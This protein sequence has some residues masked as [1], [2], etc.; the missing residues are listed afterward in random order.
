MDCQI[1]LSNEEKNEVLK[2]ANMKLPKGIRAGTNI[3]KIN[4]IRVSGNCSET[5]MEED[6]DDANVPDIIDAYLRTQEG[7]KHY[8]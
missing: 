4:T 2:T 6:E 1:L 3:V 7:S 5:W 8:Q